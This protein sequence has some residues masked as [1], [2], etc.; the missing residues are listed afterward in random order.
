MTDRV[1]PQAPFTVSVK[2]LCELCWLVLS[3]QFFLKVSYLFTRTFDE[4]DSSEWE[5]CITFEL[6]ITLLRIMR[7]TYFHVS[8][9]VGSENIE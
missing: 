4:F 8:T 2:G 3:K 7:D 6:V 1:I 5:W 9:T